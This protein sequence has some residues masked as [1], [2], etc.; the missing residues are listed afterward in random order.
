MAFIKNNFTHQGFGANAGNLSLATS[1]QD[2]RMNRWYPGWDWGSTQLFPFV[3]DVAAFDPATI[4]GALS[5]MDCGGFVGRIN[6]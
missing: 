2:Q 1:G 6:V 4:M 5:L 3:E